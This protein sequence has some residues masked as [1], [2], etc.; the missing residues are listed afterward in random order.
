MEMRA[1]IA[2]RILART[3]PDEKVPQV[4]LL[5]PSPYEGSPEGE[6]SRAVLEMV[7]L[8]EA[9]NCRVIGGDGKGKS[10]MRGRHCARFLGGMFF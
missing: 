6:T 1:D 3:L 4:R 9:E 5:G 8:W 2:A 7:E 10:F